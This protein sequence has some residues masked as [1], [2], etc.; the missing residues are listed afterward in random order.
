MME[1]PHDA[2]TRFQEPV[3]PPAVSEYDL[4]LMGDLV[5]LSR[6]VRVEQRTRW[7]NGILAFDRLVRKLR[8]A[9]SPGGSAT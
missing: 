2:A 9:R 3:I 4:E 5:R 6:E 7:H 1:I 8:H